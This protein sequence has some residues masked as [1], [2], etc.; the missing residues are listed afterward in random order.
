[1]S[2]SSNPVYCRVIN[3]AIVEYPVYPEYITARGDPLS[4]YTLVQDVSKPA[5]G[6]YQYLSGYPRL[7]GNQAFMEYTVNDI[8]LQQ[9]LAQA[10]GVPNL[11]PL[12]GLNNQNLTPPVA[13]SIDPGL[14]AAIQ[15]QV[16]NQVQNLLDSFA[17][18][19]GYTNMASLAGYYNSTVPTFKE[20][21]AVGIA[22]RDATWSSLYTFLAEVQAGAKPFIKSFQDVMA[23]LPIMS[24]SPV[25]TGNLNVLADSINTYTIANYNS[26]VT[27]TVAATSGTVTVS[28]QTITYTAPNAIGAAGFTVNGVNVVVNVT[29]AAGVSL[30]GMLSLA[31]SAVGTYTIEGYSTSTTYIATVS[32]GSV[33][34]TGNSVMVTAPATSGTIALTV[35]ETNFTIPVTTSAV[36]PA[37][38][39]ALQVPAGTTSTY[40]ITDYASTTTYTAS[41]TSGSVSVSGSSITYTAP[42]TKGAAGFTL[43]GNSYS[44][45]AI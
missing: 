29:A 27:Y 20:E 1:M 33:S 16:E 19:K 5:V 23:I 17:Q 8:P 15:T 31:T 40:T 22:V 3:G 2:T 24:W 14:V 18:Q 37:V 13:S 6:P 11:S 28:G 9:L 7:L 44:V 38:S 45:T 4:F 39:G 32:S 12:P 36:S 42:T 10:W 34:V 25:V 21:A 41:A 30:S 43:N 35:N 26:A